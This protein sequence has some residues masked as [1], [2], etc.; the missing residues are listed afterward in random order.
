MPLGPFDRAIDPSQ[1]DPGV[2]GRA[3]GRSLDIETGLELIAIIA[4]GQNRWMFKTRNLGQMSHRGRDDRQVEAMRLVMPDSVQRCQ[5]RNYYRVETAGISLPQA[6]V[7]PLL[8]PKSVVL[9]ERCNEIQFL[10]DDLN[11]LV[12]LDGIRRAVLHVTVIGH[13]I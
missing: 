13:R 7:W 11:D 12:G 4:V 3:S 6:E 9:A 2:L 1:Q 10:D 5:R 8:D